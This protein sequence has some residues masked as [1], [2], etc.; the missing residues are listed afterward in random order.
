MGAVEPLAKHGRRQTREVVGLMSFCLS[1]SLGHFFHPKNPMIVGGDTWAI[2]AVRTVDAGVAAWK[3]GSCHPFGP[4]V[5][6]G[7]RSGFPRFR[8]RRRET[9]VRETARPFS[10]V[11]S[12]DSFQLPIGQLGG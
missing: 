11:G 6:G 2:E 8:P 1:S 7:K 4:L 12:P 9:A 10:G 3:D 5:Q